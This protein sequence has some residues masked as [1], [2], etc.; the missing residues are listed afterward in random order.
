MSDSARHG[1]VW[2][3]GWPCT[4]TFG[5]GI[6]LAFAA[7]IGASVVTRDCIWLALA[8]LAIEGF[9]FVLCGAQWLSL[10]IGPVL[11]RLRLL[12]ETRPEARLDGDAPQLGAWTEVRGY[13]KVIEA[14]RAPYTGELVAAYC[15]QSDLIFDSD[16]DTL[17]RSQELGHVVIVTAGRAVRLRGRFALLDVPFGVG[18]TT[19]RDGDPIVA[20]GRLQRGGPETIAV[21]TYRSNLPVYELSADASRPLVLG[22]ESSARRLKGLRRVPS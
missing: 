4:A 2:L 17:L 22:R 15:A 6:V 11:R 14:V 21:T 12:A 20:R 5:F 8:I 19:I 1:Y 3:G 7:A 13:A 16:S 9:R 10:R 18:I